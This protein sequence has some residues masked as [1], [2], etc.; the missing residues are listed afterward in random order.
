MSDYYTIVVP[1]DGLPCTEQ[2]FDAIMADLQDAEDADGNEPHGFAI[3][4]EAGLFFLYAEV[5]GEWD[6]L[7]ETARAK[8]GALIK[9][10]EREFWEFG[11][12]FTASRLLPGSHGGTAFRIMADGSITSPR[13]MWEGE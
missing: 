12:A 9:A 5:S 10:D 2:E 6:N 1:E 4:L 13:I 8:I 11:V 3:I 7:P